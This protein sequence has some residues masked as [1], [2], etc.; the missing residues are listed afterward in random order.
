VPSRSQSFV[1]KYVSAAKDQ[2]LNDDG[3]VQGCRTSALSGNHS[4]IGG[5]VSGVL[6]RRAIAAVGSDPVIF[7]GPYVWRAGTAR[8]LNAQTKSLLIRGRLPTF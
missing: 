3:S 8:M 6:D 1:L 5:S 2:P 4:L 7:R